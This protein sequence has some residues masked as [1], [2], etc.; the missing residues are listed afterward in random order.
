MLFKVLLQQI[1]QTS[2]KVPLRVVLV[3]PFVF[4]T[5]ATVGLVGWLSLRSGQKAVNDVATQLRGEVTA[6]IQQELHAYLMIPHWINQSNADAIRIEQIDVNN[7]RSLHRHFWNQMRLFGSVSSIAF[8]SKAGEFVSVGRPGDGR[9]LRIGL[10]GKATQGYFQIY[11]IEGEG[12]RGKLLTVA[13]KYDPRRRPWYQVTVEAGKPTWSEI[14]TDFF[15]PRLAITVGQ[16]IYNAQGQLLGVMAIDLVLSQVGDFLRGLKIGQSGQ[17]FI[18]ERSGLLVA[19]SAPE[20]PF[21]LNSK[22]GKPQRMKASSSRKILIQAAAKHLEKEFGDLHKINQSELLTF[23]IDGRRQFLQVKPLS[24]GEGLDWLIAVVVPESDFMEQ[25]YGNTRSTFLLC[26]AALLL[27]IIVGILTSQWIIQPI[28]SLNA[29][30]SAL[31]Q[32]NWQYQVPVERDD[33][34]GGLAKAFHQIALQLRDY[35]V[36]LEERNEALEIRVEARTAAIREANEKLLSEVAER[37][38]IEAA[39]RESEERYRTIVENANDLITTISFDG[40]YIYVSPNYPKVLGY[41]VEELTGKEWQPFIHPEDLKKLIDVEQSGITK[42]EN[43]TS[44]EYRVLRKDGSWRWYVSTVSYARDSDGNALYFVIISRDVTERVEAEE[45]LRRAKEAAEAANRAKSEFLANVSHELRTPLN[46]ILGYAQILKRDIEKTTQNHQVLAEEN[47]LLTPQFQLSTLSKWGEGIGIIQNCGEHLLTLINDILDLS[48]I[49]ARR[50]ELQ[51]SDFNFPEF[52]KTLTDLFRIRAEQKGISFIYEPLSELPV[53][54]KADEKRLRQVLINLLGNAVKFTEKG[55]VAF[56]IGYR[57]DETQPLMNS[58]TTPNSKPKIRFQIEDTGIGIPANQLA[59]IF[60]PFQQAGDVSRLAEGTGLGLPISQKLVKMMGGEI[61]VKSQ[62]NLGSIFWFE[63]DLPEVKTCLIPPSQ[64]QFILGYQGRKRKVLVVDDKWENRAV[65]VNLLSPLGFEM[66]EAADGN[67][68]LKVAMEFRPDV[69]LMDLV[70]PGMDGFEAT[71]QL[72]DSRIL[73]KVLV[74][75]T[76]A[77]AF[78]HD[79]Q[80]SLSS[81]CDDFIPKPVRRQD[82]LERLQLHLGLEWIY[83]ESESVRSISG[84]RALFSSPIVPPAS[85][86]NTL[87]EL[88]KIGDIS[89]ILERTTHIE[90][91]GAEFVPFV[92]EVRQFAKGFQVKKLREFLAQYKPN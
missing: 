44:P 62:L 68:C 78:N 40:K 9:F 55:G 75:A 39:L 61:Y 85:E 59:E 31:T 14:Y 18:I 20:K 35:F 45:K 49:E 56:K 64:E 50:M 41:E 11:D 46:G 91:M 47:E 21:I 77:S 12:N 72:R 15:D 65:L 70:M 57:V 88:A 37:Q 66:M 19:S 54:V 36:A 8:G 26:L 87:F 29:A 51:V 16:P 92:T 28:V 67:D 5:F 27:A 84:F 32:G 22:T 38:R 24:D 6:R 53:A 1:S 90:Q 83:E 4:Q 79:Q 76:S 2:R 60:L 86:I 52:V 71:R 81:G 69:I 58:E 23:E 89:S 73:K 10:A 7:I 80:Q 34:L 13:Q 42:Q 74:I 82:I 43:L 3:V 17:T 33:E 25:I 30:A 48:K 63:L